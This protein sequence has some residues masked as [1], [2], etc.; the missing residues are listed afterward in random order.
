MNELKSYSTNELIFELYNQSDSLVRDIEVS[1]YS[2]P[3]LNTIKEIITLLFKRPEFT[4]KDR[5]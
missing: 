4:Q 5:N 2:K 3:S 1:V